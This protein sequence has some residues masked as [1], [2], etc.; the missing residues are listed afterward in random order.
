MCMP[1][2]LALA[3][4]LVPATLAAHRFWEAENEADRTQ[5]RIHFAR[6][7]PILGGLL[8]TAADTAG[9]RASSG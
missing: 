2:S 3:V 8:I 7:L 9:N 6:N 5:K 1:S 4:T